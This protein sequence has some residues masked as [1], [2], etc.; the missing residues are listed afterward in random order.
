MWGKAGATYI[1]L[2]DQISALAGVLGQHHSQRGECFCPCGWGWA[3]VG[4]EQVLAVDRSDL[5]GPSGE[6][7]SQRDREGDDEV[8]S[9]ALKQRM[10]LLANHKVDV[11]LGA[12]NLVSDALELELGSRLHAGFDSDLDVL[13]LALYSALTIECLALNL[14]LFLGSGEQP[15]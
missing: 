4:H 12:L 2:D 15:V 11:L 10:R 13:I 9:L 14:E 6:G 7:V 5:L 1:D 8:V 3:T